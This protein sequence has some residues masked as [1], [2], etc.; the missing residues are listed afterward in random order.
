[1]KEHSQNWIGR[2]LIR[3]HGLRTHPWLQRFG[4]AVRARRLWHLSRQGVARGAAVGVCCGL[5]FPV[6]QIPVAVAAS[7]VVR[8]Y[9]PLAAVST[10]VSNPLTFPPIYYGAY[11]LGARILGQPPGEV[12]PQDL[13]PHQQSV[14]GWWQLM[15]H[16]VARLGKPLLVGLVVFAG[17]GGPLAYVVAD[18]A[19]VLGERARR[20][21][22]RSRR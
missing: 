3:A 19:W 22:A 1:M 12:T 14:A 21:R 20:R 16:R 10:L 2:A 13:E 8:A 18:R 17:I 4:G 6:A 7:V 5:L 9:V 11:R 15:W